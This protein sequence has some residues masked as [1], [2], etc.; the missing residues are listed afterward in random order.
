MREGP[1]D[2]CST[3]RMYS[4]AKLE[5]TMA[6]VNDKHA[7]A[8][9]LLSCWTIALVYHR[10]PHVPVWVSVVATQLHWERRGGAHSDRPRVSLKPGL[11]VVGSWV[12]VNSLCRHRAT[13]KSQI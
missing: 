6:C 3:A 2:C 5:N 10:P 11:P 13:A 4:R 9:W 8:C 12:G 7:G 1:S